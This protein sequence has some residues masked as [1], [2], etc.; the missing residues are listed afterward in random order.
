MK[1]S[2]LKKLIREEI[3]HLREQPVGPSS[4]DCS[5]FVDSIPVTEGEFCI[6]CTTDSWN[7]SG[8]EDWCECCT[9]G[10]STGT[11]TGGNVI[12]VPT[13]PTAPFKGKQKKARRPRR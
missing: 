7:L 11:T 6:K 4:I 9:A 8:Y 3:R 12:S 13:N 1:L 5:H 2:Q 10:G